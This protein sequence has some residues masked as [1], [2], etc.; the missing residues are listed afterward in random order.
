MSI[1]NLKLFRERYSYIIPIIANRMKRDEKLVKKYIELAI[2][3]HDLLSNELHAG[4]LLYSIYRELGDEE[5]GNPIV[6][7]VINNKDLTKARALKSVS[8]YNLLKSVEIN[9]IE[10]ERV[11][12]EIDVDLLPRI[13]KVLENN[14]EP[15]Q[16]R[17]FL[18]TLSLIN[19]EVYILVLIALNLTQKEVKR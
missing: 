4:Y 17:K 2:G 7:A 8:N 15:M 14:P 9:K 18:S 5:L 3:L 16:I 12:K 19:P 1:E 6:F 13:I 10:I 11:I